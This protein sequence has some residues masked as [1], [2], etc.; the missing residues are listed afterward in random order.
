M[1]VGRDLGFL[2]G[3]VVAG[4]VVICGTVIWCVL[5]RKWR[6]SVARREEIKRLL[7]LASEETARAELEASS[8]VYGGCGY[9][10]TLEKKVEEELPEV[11]DFKVEVRPPV[12]VELPAPESVPAIRI[13]YQCE[14]CFSP[15]TTRCKQCKSVHYWYVCPNASC[16]LKLFFFISFSSECNF[17]EGSEGIT[18]FLTL[19][20]SKWY[21]VVE[22]YS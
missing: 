12:E 9:E 14:V 4:F 6:R 22:I 8:G 13:Q 2:A 15:T 17:W 18:T 19:H 11:P 10:P 16:F 5:S 7:V 1:L 20:G 21:F 3:V